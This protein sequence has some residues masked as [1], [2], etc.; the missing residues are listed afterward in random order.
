MEEIIFEFF[1]DQWYIYLLVFA[2]SSN[3]SNRIIKYILEKDVINECKKYNI[4][5]KSVN[6]TGGHST[7]D[8]EFIKYDL[9]KKEFKQS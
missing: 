3:Q 2:N 9:N 6:Y 5:V 8:N 1:N 7:M 4:K